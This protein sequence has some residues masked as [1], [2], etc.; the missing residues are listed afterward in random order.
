M[1]I[2]TL[3]SDFG[4][5]DPDLAVVKSDILSQLQDIQLVD[6]T[7]DLTPFDKEEAVYILKNSLL[8]FPDGTIHLIAFHSESFIN[9]K[10]ILIKTDKHFFLC[11]D[12]GVVPTI[13]E[14]IDYVAYYLDLVDFESFMRVHIESLVNIRNDA[15]PT[16][17]TKKATNLKKL[18]LPKPILE[19]ED[20]IV[21]TI[22]TKVIYVDNY[23]NA[24]F[25]LSKDY[26]EELAQGRKIITKLRFDEIKGLKKG[27]NNFVNA[28]FG[29]FAGQYAARFN[30]Y[31][32]F[33]VFVNSSNDESGGANT[34]LGLKKG[35]SVRI[36]FE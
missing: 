9:N 25:N 33:E 34:L 22:T 13:L 29:V 3:T 2:V 32:H 1:T 21:K 4:T 15:F 8:N 6:I 27:Y 24:V 31:N 20:N 23:G 30:A 12:N 28:K 26:F 36:I 10:P 5:K 14:G 19:Y 11:N 7:H 17:F 35:E 16:L 18:S